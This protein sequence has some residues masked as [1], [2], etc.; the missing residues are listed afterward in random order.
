MCP[1]FK[2]VSLHHVWLTIE[3]L[4]NTRRYNRHQKLLQI[5]VIT[6]LQQKV[7]PIKVNDL[8]TIYGMAN[9]SNDLPTI[10]EMPYVQKKAKP[11]LNKE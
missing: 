11:M 6:Y 10:E 5:K 9:T 8:L 1:T 3:R 2:K 7:W 4:A